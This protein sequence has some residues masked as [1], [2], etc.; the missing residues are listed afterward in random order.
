MEQQ[1]CHEKWVRR[2]TLLLVLGTPHL[3]SVI[4]VVCR[5]SFSHLCLGCGAV[6][7]RSHS[8]AAG[9]PRNPAARHSCGASGWRARGCIS[10]WWLGP[11]EAESLP[12]VIALL[13]QVAESWPGDLKVL[14]SASDDDWRR[15]QCRC[16]RCT[17]LVFSFFLFQV[18]F[19][20]FLE[21]CRV[22]YTQAALTE[23]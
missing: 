17:L 19:F 14:G 9:E 2:R 15:G 11:W 1:R 4:A 22:L 20:I 10:L 8:R 13:A 18:C 5:A 12:L 3:S 23:S 6:I 7:S 16:L 21:T